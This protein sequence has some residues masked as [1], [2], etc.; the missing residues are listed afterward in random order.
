MI[1]KLKLGKW[2]FKFI[3]APVEIHGGVNSNLPDGSHIL[4]WD[5]DDVSLEQ[6][7]KELLA[8]QYIYQ[9]PNIYILNSGKPNHWVCFCRKRLPFWLACHIISST[10]S[11]D[12]NF[13]RYGVWRG[14]FTIRITPKNGKVPKLTEVL[15]GYTKEDV[16]I[17]ELKSFDYYDAKAEW[18]KHKTI[19]IPRNLEHLWRQM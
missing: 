19:S 17:E 12:R 11:V 18:Y 10:P 16:E 5:F 6:V 15:E 8:T 1:L 14:Y 3:A 4:M 2:L 13:Y 7:R 9:L